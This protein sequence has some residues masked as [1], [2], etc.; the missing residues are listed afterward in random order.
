[1]KLLCVLLAHFPLSCETARN[2][3]LAGRP[4]VVV[5]VSGSQ[6]LVLDCSPELDRLQPGLPLQQA[7]SRCGEVELVQADIPHYLS[8]YDRI[9]DRLGEISP[10]VEGAALGS[11]YL[12]L[13]G[14]HLIYPDDDAIV[15]ALHGA[16]PEGFAPQAGIAGNKFLAGLAARYSPPGGYRGLTGE[17]T[18]GFLADLPCDVLPVS[19]K[20]LARLYS[21]GINTLDQVAGLPP[22]PLQAQFG[23]E[24]IVIRELARGHDATPLY[25]HQTAESFDES[26]TLASVTASLEPIMAVMESL[27]NR[28]FSKIAATGKGIRSLTLWTRTWDARQWEKSIRFKEPAMDARAAVFRIRHTLEDFSQPG[29]VEQAGIRITRLGYPGGRQNSLLTEVRAGH[30]L[31]EDIRQLELRLGGPQVYQV[32]EMEPWSRIPERRYALTPSSSGR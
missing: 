4:A 24:G 9:L 15:N 31:K 18:A 16:V 17:D 7:L 3:A 2:P 1:M 19:P 12:G 20:S 14:L 28:V 11:A 13:D 29:P 21:L 27:L 5:E 32:K 10:L 25:P 6:K 23:P 8:V 22:G 30:N 26:L